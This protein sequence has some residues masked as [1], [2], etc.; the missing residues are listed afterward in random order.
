MGA[1][2][3]GVAMGMEHGAGDWAALGSQRGRRPTDR[4]RPDAPPG[5][6][7]LRWAALSV[8]LPVCSQNGQGGCLP[9]CGILGRGGD[10]VL[11]KPVAD[12]ACTGRI[13]AKLQKFEQPGWLSSLA[14]PSAQGLILETRDRVPCRAPCMEPASPSA[15]LSLCVSHE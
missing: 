7:L 13:C 6:A 5:T 15:P 3:C 12:G 11:L 9:G 4:G 10:T 2:A 14:L 1:P 8:N